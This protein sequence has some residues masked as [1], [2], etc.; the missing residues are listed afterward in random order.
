M[1]FS[2]QGIEDKNIIFKTTK[3]LLEKVAIYFRGREIFYGEFVS[4][5]KIFESV[6]PN[7]LNKIYCIAY[8][9]CADIET[10]ILSKIESDELFKK[11]IN[12]AME[13]NIEDD[14]GD[15][16]DGYMKMLCEHVN[17]NIHVSGFIEE[18]LSIEYKYI[19]NYYKLMRTL[20][21][22]TK[23]VSGVW[24]DSLDLV[25][26]GFYDNAKLSSKSFLY[27]SFCPV[28][29]RDLLWLNM[30]GHKEMEDELVFQECVLSFSKY[31]PEEH[32]REMVMNF[33]TAV[34]VL[35]A[36]SIVNITSE[37]F[38]LFPMVRQANAMLYS[39]FRHKKEDVYSV[40]DML[41]WIGKINMGGTV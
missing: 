19:D 16:K 28:S 3:H 37:N 5:D 39:K 20:N 17:A 21:N 14:E 6:T 33:S 26:V 22:F 34:G 8:G 40:K 7:E 10:L 15:T 9:V 24:R 29:E 30:C 36:E 38:S 2:S 4:T 41:S 18:S 27:D 23:G 12:R 31:E 32:G 25:A 13:Q 11:M 35:G 1:T